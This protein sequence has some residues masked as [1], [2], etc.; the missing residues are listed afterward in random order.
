MKKLDKAM[1]DYIGKLNEYPDFAA[2]S[3]DMLFE[4]C[5]KTEAFA[6]LAQDFNVSSIAVGPSDFEKTMALMAYVHQELFCVGNH[7]S[8]PDNTYDIMKAR[9]TGALFCNYHATVLSE[10]LLSIGIQAVKIACTPKDF[11]GDRHVAVLAHMKDLQKWIFFDPTFH[12]CFFDDQNHPLGIFEIREQYKKAKNIMFKPIE[13][14][15]QWALVMNGLVCKTYDEWYRIYMAKNCF[16]FMFPKKTV[17]NPIGYETK[18]EY[19]EAEL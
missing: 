15:K 1:R 17:I 4:L 3:E 16:R 10:L 5:G 14:D 19:D 18:N 7:I 11:D 8:P 9:K 2:D 13:I 12:T 6:K